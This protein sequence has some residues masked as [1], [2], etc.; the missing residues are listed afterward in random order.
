MSESVRKIKVEATGLKALKNEL[1]EVKN[2]LADATN[3]DD[4]K[5]LSEAAAGLTDQI[6]DLN[7]EI[8]SFQGSNFEQVSGQL[9]KIGDSI[10]NLDFEKSA[11][12]ANT[13][14]A[15]S[16][17]M[18]FKEAISGVK[19]MGSTFINL[20]KALLTNPLFLI[21]AIIAGIVIAIYKFLDSLGLIKKAMEVV[22]AA[23]DY[24]IGLFKSLTDW[25]GIS[26]YAAQDAAE[27]TAKAYEESANRQAQSSKEAIAGIDNRIRMAKL[28]GRDVTDLERQKRKELED[29]AKAQMLSDRAKYKSALLNTDLTKEEIAEIKAK[30][31]ESRLA[32]QQTLADTKYFEAEIRK[33]KKDE[34]IKEDDDA[35]KDAQ[36]AAKDAE[37]RR[38]EA[39]AKRKAYE[40]ARIQASRL[41][42]DLEL[43]MMSQGID[44]E[45]ALN[46]EKYKRLIED[47][48]RNEK[49]TQTERDLIISQYQSLRTENEQKL[50]KDSNDKIREQ[51]L[52]AQEEYSNMIFNLT[53]SKTQ[54]E[55]QKIEQD[56]ITKLDLLKKQLSEGLITQE[57]FNQAEVALAQDKQNKLNK[58]AGGPGGEMDPLQAARNKA[59]EQLKIQKEYFDL[60]LIDEV[61]YANRRKQ[62]EKELNDEIKKLDAESA[63]QK[64]DNIN[65]YLGVAS[66]GISAISSLMEV[67]MEN[68]IKAAEGNEAKQEQLRK[69]AFEQQKKM[70]I[71]AAFINMA[72]GIISGLG[73]PFPMNIAL[74]VIAGVTGLANIAKIK[75]TTFEGGGGGGA[76]TPTSP[77]SPSSMDRMG[78]SF[79][80]QGNGG[81]NN[82]VQAGGPQPMAITIQNEVSV[83]ETEITDTQR[84]VANLT[85]SA[86][87]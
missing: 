80:F 45:I 46:E 74:P 40:E 36:Q 32:Y 82:N 14:I 69:K 10:K 56:N 42:R 16:Q 25:L 20:G 73:A 60:G 8:K 68:E 62:I 4:I 71:A 2:A 7:D 58:I 27:A 41:T 59:E 38:K 23:I 86:K 29:T 37:A 84:T 50:R 87:I 49:L 54:Q 18:T 31:R 24:V 77:S 78:P 19:N 79:N 85:N 76:A 3:P 72:Q 9:G 53:S 64:R 83:S 35:K 81:G 15:L 65:N 48:T 26:S 22:G 13:L 61:D 6:S 47:T 57:Q 5:N 43:E 67:S 28:E 21:A 30:A 11:Q 39:E 12:Q 51:E 66:Q 33:T 75:S 70:Q 52:K 44:K 55:V 34:K 17:K 63:Q 1:R